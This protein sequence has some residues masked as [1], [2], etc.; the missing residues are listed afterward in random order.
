MTKTSFYVQDPS[1]EHFFNISYLH[2]GCSVT[3][4]SFDFK[5]T[6]PAAK[7]SIKLDIIVQVEINNGKDSSRLKIIL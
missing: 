1:Q 4:G 2:K 7:L 6:L 5:L 3:D